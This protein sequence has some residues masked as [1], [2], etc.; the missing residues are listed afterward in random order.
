MSKTKKEIHCSF[1]GVRKSDTQKLIAGDDAHICDRC[2]NHAADILAD[3]L[4]Q[5]KQNSMQT[6]LELIRHSEIEKHLDEF[7]IGQDAA[8]KSI[9]VAVYNH[10]KRL[11]HQVSKDEIEIEKSNL[12]IVGET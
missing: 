5:S 6:A 12:I 10:Y 7:V 9:S 11:N 1:C 4:R 8:K 2:V 3:E